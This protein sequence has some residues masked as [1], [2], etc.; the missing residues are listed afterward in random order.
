MQRH[1]AAGFFVWFAKYFVNC[2]RMMRVFICL[3][4]FSQFGFSARAQEQ[5]IPINDSQKIDWLYTVAV[6]KGDHHFSVSLMKNGLLSYMTWVNDNTNT[7]SR[8]HL[9]ELTPEKFLAL[10]TR[11][12]RL[13]ADCLAAGLRLNQNDPISYAFDQVGENESR[14]L[15]FSGKVPKVMGFLHAVGQEHKLNYPF[16]LE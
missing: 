13:F 10:Q 8:E 1:A 12:E 3:L 4:I 15:E 2:Y 14:M 5:V 16:M 7:P 11:L 9:V 6:Q